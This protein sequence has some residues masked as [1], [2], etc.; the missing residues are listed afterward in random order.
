MNNPLDEEYLLPEEEEKKKNKKRPLLA[1]LLNKIG[2]PTGPFTEWLLDWVQVI[3][4][5]VLLAWFVMTFVV[6]RMKVPTGSMKPT[7]QVGSSFF[8]DKISY[9]FRKPNPGD[10]IVFWH[11]EGDKRVRYVKRLIAVGGQTVEI[12]DGD[13]YING[14]KLEG[15]AFDRY[16]YCY[17][18]RMNNCKWTVPEGKYFVLGDNSRNSLD[19][20]YWGFAD[21][22]DFIGEPFLRVW[23]LDRIGFMN[24]YLG[25]SR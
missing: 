9:Y 7:I 15:P 14:H 17:P 5:A 16:Y 24:G 23:P 1:R 3:G 22:K 12:K 2:I 20:R 18:N 4:V 11:K 10:I 13:I 25:A 8:V 21:A 6:V 19:S